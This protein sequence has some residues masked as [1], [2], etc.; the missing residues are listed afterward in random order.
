MAMVINF[1]RNRNLERF[2]YTDLFAYFD[3]LPNCIVSSDDEQVIMV[4]H[5]ELF[6]LKYPF[7]ITKR[8]RISNIHSI[9]AQYVNIR[10]L[11]E[12]PEILPEPVSR[13]VL[14]VIDNLCQ[15]FQLDVY[16]EGAKD[17]EQFDMLHMMKVYSDN[18]QKYLSENPECEYYTLPSDVIT[19][20][21]NY[22]QLIPFLK[23][24]IKENVEMAEYVILSEPYKKE[25]ILAVDW[26]PGQKILFPPHLDYVRIEILGEKINIP[27]NI[28]LKYAERYMYELKNYL[29]SHSLL[30]LTNKGMKKVIRRIKKMR[31]YQKE[32]SFDEISI[33]QVIEN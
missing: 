29:P 15:K 32:V 8:S 1:F 23:E 4:Y 10:F 28:F 20:M 12:I 22:Q 13:Q 21:C 16:Y 33:I 27:M 5:D 18:R 3:E 19:H 24:R 17:A 9:S 26:V 2:D 25:A 7:Y 31:K 14:S 11:V 6:N 30:M